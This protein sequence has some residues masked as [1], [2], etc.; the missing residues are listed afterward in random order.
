MMIQRESTVNLA[1]AITD[2]NEHT[3]KVVAEAFKSIPKQFIP[4][5]EPV[6]VHIWKLVVGVRDIRI[7]LAKV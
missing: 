1:K 2:K 5:D 6:D 4:N 3:T 7:E